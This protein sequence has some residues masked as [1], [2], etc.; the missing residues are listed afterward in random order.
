MALLYRYL[1]YPWLSRNKPM[2]VGGPGLARVEPET[3][4]PEAADR[5]VETARELIPAGFTTAFHFRQPDHPDAPNRQAYLA[6]WLHEADGA[7]ARAVWIRFVDIRIP[8]TMTSY[9]LSF[10]TAFDDGREVLTTNAPLASVF[11]PVPTIDAVGWRDMSHA[12][13]LWKLHRARSERLRDGRAVV[14]P[15]ADAAGI[16][17]LVRDTEQRVIDFAIGRGYLRCDAA[18]TVRHTMRGAY[19]MTWRLLWPWKQLAVARQARK[20]RRVLAEFPELAA[21]ARTLPPTTPAIVERIG[22]A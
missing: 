14:P 16:E 7:V 1:V 3:I 4:L 10:T 18:G 19:L 17:K 8:F 21:E 15:P 20:L 12:G 22:L 11:P 2:A 9:A 13:M 5:F 6:V